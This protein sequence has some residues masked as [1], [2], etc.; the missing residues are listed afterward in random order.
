MKLPGFINEDKSARY[1]GGYSDYIV[2]HE[3]QP[4]IGP[5]AGWRGK[6]EEFGKGEVNPNQLDKYIENGCFHFHE[7]K[8]EQ[9]YYLAAL[10]K[11]S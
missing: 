8:K 5:L 10:I 1:P 3:R 11:Y 7:L 6:G 4:G 2:N 9:R